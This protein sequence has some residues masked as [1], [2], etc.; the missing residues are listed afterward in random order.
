MRVKKEHGTPSRYNYGC[1]CVECKLANTLRARK[2]RKILQNKPQELI[3]HG[4][5]NAYA[6]YGCRCESCKHI[7]Q[8]E[9]KKRVRED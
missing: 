4:T 1:R 6:N 7:K 9:N 3:P 8:K 2:N 5:Y